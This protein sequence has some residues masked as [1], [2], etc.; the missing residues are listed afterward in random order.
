M[1]DNWSEY[2]L[3]EVCEK[4]TDGSHFSPKSVEHGFPMASVKD[5]TSYGIDLKSC[6][7]ISKEDYNTLVHQ[8]CK[9]INGDV[10]VAK[11][12]ATAL[13]TVCEF[14]NNLNIVLLSSIAIL[15]PNITK[16]T[17]SYLYYYM[18]CETTKQ[19]IKNGFIT[20]AAIPRVVIKDFKKCK[21]ILPDIESQK[22]ITT[23]LSKY[24]NLI[25][26]NLKRIE[27]LN[28]MAQLIYLEWFVHFRFPGHE[29]AQMIDTTIGK[30]PAVWDVKKLNDVASINSSKI[31]NG[32]EPKEINYIDISSVSIGKID[33]IEKMAYKDAP[34][35]AKRIVKHGDTIWSMVRPN[36]KSFSIIIKPLANTVV[37]TGFA[38][39][40]P[41]KIPYSY[42]YY[43]ITTDTFTQYLTNN[44]TGS[45]YPAVNSHD[46]EDADIL[47]PPVH[48]LNEFHSFIEPILNQQ[49]I[50]L[51]QNINLKKTRELILLKLI[52]GELDVSNLDIYTSNLNNRA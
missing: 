48:I 33:K 45:A 13:D 32:D 17:S 6:R 20:G 31:K 40:T 44:A 22:K 25:V 52:S 4:I 23:I 1:R 21:I 15:R 37:S 39:I 24:D 34:G 30:I 14:R 12:G 35:R 29:K 51:E 2:T 28:E 18:D 47:I 50:L 27:L 38:V 16:V 3:E 26:N 19:Y 36:R 9:P 43:A 10:L 42:I 46:F 49:H 8:G 5:L 41:I 11:D 7:K